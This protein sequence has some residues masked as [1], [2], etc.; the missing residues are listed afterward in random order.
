MTTKKNELLLISL[1]LLSVLGFVCFTIIYN[2]TKNTYIIEKKLENDY[3]ECAYVV[4]NEIVILWQKNCQSI[5]PKIK[6]KKESK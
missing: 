6:L 5:I 3:Q 1:T 4:G 2:K